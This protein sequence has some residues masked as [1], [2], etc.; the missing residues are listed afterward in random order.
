MEPKAIGKSK[1]DYLK[2]ILIVLKEHGACRNVDVS[3]RLAV[4]IQKMVES[5][6]A[7]VLFTANPINGNENEM[8]INASF[9]LG[10]SVVSG[11]VTTDSFVCGKDGKVIN[12]V[13]GEKATEIIYSE[14]S[15]TVEVPIDENRRK[16]SSLDDELLKELCNIQYVSAEYR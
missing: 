8:Q 4:V 3:V 16:I 1:E 2:A 9:G 13:I 7:G 10:E 11:R 5:E 14:N 6:I 15:G 12:T